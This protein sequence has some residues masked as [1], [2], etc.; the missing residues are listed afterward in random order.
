MKEVPYFIVNAGGSCPVLHLIALFK[1][2]EV[3]LK[4]SSMPEKPYTPIPRA[5]LQRH[6]GNPVLSATDFPWKMRA[7]YN[8]AA[9]K[10]P[11]GRYVMLCRS[12]ELNHRTLLWGADSPDGLNWTLRAEPFAMPDTEEWRRYASTVYYDPRITFI[13]GQYIVLLACQN[14]EY[15]RVALFTSKD[16]ETLRFSHYLN[17]PDNRNMVLFPERS[18]DG[19]FMRLERPNIAAAGGKGNVW[20]SYSPDL[21][22][23]GDAKEVLQTTDVWNYGIS[24]LGPSTVPVRTEEGWLIVFHAIMNNCTTREYTAGAALLDLEDPSVVRHV[25]RYPILY[26]EAQYELQGL[27]EHVVFPCSKIVEP[28]GTLKLYYGAADTVQCVAVGK[29]ED[30]LMAC[31]EW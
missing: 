19:R 24:G 20:L 17:A 7:V 6:P 13:D 25:T 4:E 11:E 26:P 9:I 3:G 15:T 27:V 23:W 10:T 8:S 18:A 16:L 28:D 2:R 31:K 1:S 21:L 5:I 12:N 30:V 29:L 22:H 14:T